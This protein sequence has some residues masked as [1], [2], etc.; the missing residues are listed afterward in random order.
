MNAEDLLNSKEYFS[1]ERFRV[2][3]R[4]EHCVARQEM[5]TRNLYHNTEN[6]R[7]LECVNCEQ[8]KEVRK[9]LGV[10]EGTKPKKICK[11]E[12]CEK[13]ARGRGFCSTHYHHW[14]KGRL[15]I[16]GNP[17]TPA[18]GL[19][20]E[21]KDAA[22]HILIDIGGYEIMD[23]LEEAAKIHIRTVEQQALAYIIQGLK[24]DQARGWIEQGRPEIPAAS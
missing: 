17:T 2:R 20:I 8:G 3:M 16:E 9:E 22:E 14:R 12:G 10:P 1:C 6:P 19:T 7:F 5:K 11:V 18:E 23:A 24:Y 15:N 13:E 4:K 21:L